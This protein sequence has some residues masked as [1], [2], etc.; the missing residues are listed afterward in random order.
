MDIGFTTD[1]D[2]SIA[3]MKNDYYTV[4]VHE[5][6]PFIKVK[7][8]TL[9]NNYKHC[10][11]M[12]YIFCSKEDKEPCWIDVEGEDIGWVFN[13]FDDDDIEGIRGKLLKDMFYII[14]RVKNDD[15]KIII[16]QNINKSQVLIMDQDIGNNYI[17]TFSNK[18]EK[19]YG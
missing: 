10:S 16:G 4:G 2:L 13:Q 9:F 12:Y 7:I 19:Y 6:N 17:F 14:D 8:I 3:K 18:R 5:W 1:I 11:Y 15:L